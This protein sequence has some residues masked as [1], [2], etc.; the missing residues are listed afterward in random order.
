MLRLDK[1]VRNVDT[2]RTHRERSY[3]VGQPMAIARVV[4]SAPHHTIGMLLRTALL[5]ITTCLTGTHG[6]ECFEAIANT[7]I[8]F[9]YHRAGLVQLGDDI[10]G[11]NVSCLFVL[12]VTTGFI[13][14][15]PYAIITDLNHIYSEL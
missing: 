12:L 13:R 15:I 11:D 2:E 3:D 14:E 7:G 10:C 1:S 4:G 9:N 5:K 8:I 6:G